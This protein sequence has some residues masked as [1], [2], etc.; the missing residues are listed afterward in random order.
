MAMLLFEVVRPGA[1]LLRVVVL[2]AVGATVGLAVA[3]RPSWWAE[4]PTVTAAM[5]G[6]LTATNVASVSAPSPLGEVTLVVQP[7]D[8]GRNTELFRNGWEVGLFAGGPLTVVVR[9]GDVLSVVTPRSMQA[10][11]NLVVL[12]V[13]RGTVA[14][15]MGERIALRAG[16][17]VFGVVRLA[18]A[19]GDT[20]GSCY[21][22]PA[23]VGGSGIGE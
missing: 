3:G 17:E 16:R 22:Q 10:A 7:Q 21:N 13:S 2:V 11:A 23:T 12:A 19:A 15:Q 1:V 14:P 18:C 6:D 9:N 20:P 5:A 8:A 4:L